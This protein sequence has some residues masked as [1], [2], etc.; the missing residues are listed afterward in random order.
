MPGL[1]DQFA[2]LWRQYVPE[3]WRTAG[4]MAYGMGQTAMIPGQVLRSTADNPIT[5]EQLIKPATELALSVAGTSTPFAEAGAAGVFGGRLAK[6]ADLAA[7]SKAEELAAKGAHPDQIFKETGWFKGADDK[8]RFEIPDVGS[9][10]AAPPKEPGR[11][12]IAQQYLDETHPGALLGNPQYRAE[13]EA[14]LQHADT[15][16]AQTPGAPLPQILQHQSLYEAYPQLRDIETVKQRMLGQYKG[17]YQPGYITYGGGENILKADDPRSTLLHEVQHAIQDIEGFAKGGNT[18]GLKPGTPAWDIYQERRAA[19]AKPLDRETYAKVAGYEG[20]VPEKDWKAYL[21]T[22]K[23]PPAYIDRAA[24]QYGVENAYRRMAGEVEARNVQA[25]RDMT[26]EQ[27]RSTPPSTTQDV[28]PENQFVEFRKPGEI[29]LQM[30]REPAADLGETAATAA[31]NK[32]FFDYTRLGGVPDVPQTPLPRYTPPRGVPERT[33]ELV[34]NPDVREKMLGLIRQG[35]ESGAGNWYNTDQLRQAFLDELGKRKGAPAFQQ[36]MDLVAATS[37]RSKVPENVRNASYY[38]TLARRGEPMPEVGTA[39]PAPY[40]HLAQKL[41]QANAQ[42]VAATGWNPLQNPKPASF[43]QNLTGNFEPVTVDAHAFGLPAMLAE[44]PR[45]LAR[46]MVLEKGA[47]SINPTE[48]FKSGELT[49]GEALS[50][51]VYWASKPQKTEYAAIENYFRDLARES[52]L[53]PAQAQAAAWSAGGPITGLMSE[54][55]KP[56]IGFVEDRLRKTAVERDIS[57][58]EALS[59]MIRGKAPLLSVGGAAVAPLLYE[60][61]PY[62]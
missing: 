31:T 2:D 12:D 45:F 43:A 36:Y 42:A 15:T 21:K 17:S 40:G 22:V 61:Q 27:L 8:W 59:Q 46:A 56:F 35:A 9:K 26:P 29:D 3:P 20:P 33:A 48:M 13:T 55:N 28:L 6:S 39:N 54:A 23:N 25:R 1:A 24:Q 52:K 32:P 14:A 44:D 4:T 49:M 62:Q 5:T 18:F 47:P 16:L 51:P 34:T 41:H 30:A 10:Y 19:M 11:F 50:R 7:L 53:A 60:D 37:P 58:S 57:M 38:Y